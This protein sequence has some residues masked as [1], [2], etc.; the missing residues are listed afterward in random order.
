MHKA[1]S[2]LPIILGFGFGE[3]RDEGKAW[4]FPL[5]LRGQ[6]RHVN[7]LQRAT[8]PVKH[9]FAVNVRVERVLNDGLDGRKTGAARHEDDRLV[10]VFAQKKGSERSFEAKN[11]TV[12]HFVEHVIGKVSVRNQA[13]MQF[14]K[15]IV[16]WGIGDGKAAPL[17][18]F[19]QYI[20][21]LARQEL[22]AL[23]CRKL[24]RKDGNIRCDLL[25]LFDA[26]R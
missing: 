6:L 3:N 26:A 8:A 22:Q 14:H 2:A 19:E 12:A 9:H 13:H 16:M 4:V 18:I 24:E 1:G 23:L 7:V 15:F 17:A 21:V 25:L 5:P 11:G 10:R 20:E